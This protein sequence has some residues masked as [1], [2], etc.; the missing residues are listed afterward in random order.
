MLEAI[1]EWLRSPG[2]AFVLVSIIA[3][4]A[5]L[6]SFDAISAYAVRV[7]AFPPALWW[8]APLLVDTFTV[9]GG[10]VVYSRSGAQGVTWRH[11]VYPWAVVA[12][13]S[14]VSIAVNVAH[15]PEHPAARMLAALPPVALLA[16]LELVMGEARRLRGVRSSTEYAPAARQ[17]VRELLEADPDVSARIV[18]AAAGVSR[19]RAYELLREERAALSNGHREEVTV[20]P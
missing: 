20:Q 19:G 13:G 1:R 4:I 16:S 14:A 5:F 2:P 6:V 7:G 15:A 17:V 10:W 9:A 11:L 3:A 8:A 12:A 18:Q